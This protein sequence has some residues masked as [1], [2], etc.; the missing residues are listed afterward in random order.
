MAGIYSQGGSAG[1]RY[2]G[3][4]S[5]VE[6]KNFQFGG[7]VFNGSPS[8]IYVGSNLV[9]MGGWLTVAAAQAI[10]GAFGQRDGW[11]V[12]RATNAYLTQLAASGQAGKDKATAL[13]A[14]INEDP[15]MVCSLGLEVQLTV[16]PAMPIRLATIRNKSVSNHLYNG[17]ILPTPFS[18][19][20]KMEMTVN[21]PNNSTMILSGAT[22]TTGMIGY[23]SFGGN[24]SLG[25]GTITRIGTW[26]LNKLVS[27]GL[28]FTTN[29]KAQNIRIAGWT[30]ISWNYD[31]TIKQ[32]DI[33]AV[34]D[35]TPLYQ[36]VP[37]KTK[38][39]EIC[40]LNL[41]D[42]TLHHNVYIDPFTESYTLPDGTPWTPQ[43]P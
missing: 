29:T 36:L 27:V 1:H 18:Q 42:L 12:I 10:L 40:F 38:E 37:F 15:M 33:L 31:L 4:L 26:T 35:T 8:A 28:N 14:L 16:L 2:A 34:D 5:E 11:A 23:Y 25:A 24:N 39:D 41:V 9:W 17:L 21:A 30:N 19:V 20:G 6:A 3:W 13:A 43:T 32:W 22:S 7:K